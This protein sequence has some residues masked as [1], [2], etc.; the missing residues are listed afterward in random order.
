MV[1][2]KHGRTRSFPNALGSLHSK[3]FIEYPEAGAVR[4][5]DVLLL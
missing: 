1:A 4:A 3:G 5:S 2:G